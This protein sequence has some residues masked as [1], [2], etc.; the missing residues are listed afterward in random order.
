MMNAKWIPDSAAQSR[1]VFSLLGLLV[2]MIA[3]P[4]S[5]RA[6]IDVDYIDY[7]VIATVD[8]LEGVDGTT[9]AALQAEGVDV[10]ET[11]TLTASIQENKAGESVACA[12][13]S[14]ENLVYAPDDPS[15]GTEIHVGNL[16]MTNMQDANAVGV[17]DD[18]P[19]DTP[20]GPLPT[21]VFGIA[22]DTADT[23]IAR[24]PLNST[25]TDPTPGDP[26]SGD[27]TSKGS[28]M[29]G[30]QINAAGEGP[31]DNTDLPTPETLWAPSVFSTPIIDGDPLGGPR[32][33]MDMFDTGNGNLSFRIIATVDSWTATR[34]TV[35][36]PVPAAPPWSLFA[37]AA[38]LLGAG[39]LVM[40]AR[41][42]RT[43]SN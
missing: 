31:I 28:A 14:G 39:A 29:L 13:A 16:S 20:F 27:E 12:P 2:C 36:V 22:G 30:V 9:L 4:L 37:M 38:G 17:A 34:R 41:M 21:D 33:I 35:S 5:A 42:L 24:F 6:A 19:V 8:T 7:E 11:L 26:C 23:S 25:Q 1:I 10:G 43:S 3:L 40:R 18:V 15:S 32:V